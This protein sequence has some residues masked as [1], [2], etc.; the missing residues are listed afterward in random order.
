MSIHARAVA[1]TEIT[2]LRLVL[3]EEDEIEAFA[4][5]LSLGRGFG[6]LV[7]AGGECEDA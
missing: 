4:H 7:T 1:F 5:G 6:G 2:L 3:G